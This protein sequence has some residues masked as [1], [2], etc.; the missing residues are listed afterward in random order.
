MN[1]Y[2]KQAGGGEFTAK[3]YRTWAGSVHALA[4][5]QREPATD[6]RRQVK[7]TQTV[8]EIAHRLGNTPAICRSCY[9]YP[10]ILEAYL[11]GQLPACSPPKG[12]RNLNANEKRLLEFLRQHLST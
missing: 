9:I 12:S 5:L 2:L 7:I 1:A 10:A 3:H 6:G 8:K 4:A 11:N